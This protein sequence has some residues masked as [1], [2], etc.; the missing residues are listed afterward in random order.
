MSYIPPEIKGER[1]YLDFVPS[2]CSHLKGVDTSKFLLPHCAHCLLDIF[3][4]LSTENGSYSTDGKET[5][6]IS[7]SGW[8][9][10]RSKETLHGYV[11]LIRPLGEFFYKIREQ[12]T[13]KFY[14]GTDVKTFTPLTITDD[15]LEIKVRQYHKHTLS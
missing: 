3:A 9:C 4:G 14:K 11:N 10:T 2:R 15:S 7:G 5:L 6:T 12:V 1:A 8:R 13:V